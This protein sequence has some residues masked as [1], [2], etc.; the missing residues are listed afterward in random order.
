MSTLAQLR[1]RVRSYLDE[2][3]AVFWQD[4]ELNN[5][6]NQSYY[7][8]YMWVVEA[9]DS[10]FATV[11]NINIV[12]NQALYILPADFFKVRLLEAIFD[13]F[14]IPLRVYD[15]M[16]DANITSN[17]TFTNSYFPTYRFI[18]NSFTLEPTP[19]LGKS[20]GLRLEYVPNPT[21]MV[22]D[23]SAP[24][25]DFAEQWQELIVLG[26]TISA[27][28]KEELVGNQGVDL[29]ALGTMLSKWESTVREA[30]EQRSQGRRY[31]Q[32]FGLDETSSYFYP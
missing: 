29:G 26:A 2:P 17:F 28:M 11:V 31:T 13:G 24:N 15:R 30:I 14:T 5:W 19:S 4:S 20:P 32:I 10:Y 6:I 9:Y 1:T 25:A 27:K 7:H 8:Y 12:A 3:S 21:T 16:E 22:L 18:G 23:T